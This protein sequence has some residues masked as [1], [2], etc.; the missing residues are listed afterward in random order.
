MTFV[1]ALPC[2]VI[3]YFA[4]LSTGRIVLWC[5]LIWYVGTVLQR[6]DPKPSIWLN[7]MG[8]SVV[9]GVALLLSVGRPAGSRLERWAVFRLFLMPFCVS[10]F[11]SLIKGQGYVLVFPP[12]A[13]E[14]WPLLGACAAFV[15]GVAMLRW[16]WRPWM[17]PD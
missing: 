1:S 15:A 14:L 8:L 2:R 4:K 12:S 10:S 13:R 5:Y 17:V 6:F 7:A 16:R 11:S 3:G 9:I